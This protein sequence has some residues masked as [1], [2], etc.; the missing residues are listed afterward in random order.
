MFSYSHFTFKFNL[1]HFISTRS[2][3]MKK[4]AL[5]AALGLLIASPLLSHAESN[6]VT[7]A[8]ATSATAKLD[9]QIVIPKVL[10]LRIGT[11]TD[12]AINATVDMLTFTVPPAN[13]GNGTAVAGTGGDLTAGAVTVRA[14]G[15]GGNPI[16]LNSTTAG[17]LLSGTDSIPWS[18]ITVTPAALGATT[19]GFTNAAITH[20][21]FNTGGAGGAGTATTLTAGAAKVARVEGKWTFAYANTAFVPAGTYGAPAASGRVTYTITQ[22]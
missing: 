15:N 21:A 2:F 10:Y 12:N 20:P 13:V 1:F 9:F 7:G 4:L 14:Y 22:P 6:Y 5:T 17:P 16:T 18:E 11:G 19:A 8:G 3:T